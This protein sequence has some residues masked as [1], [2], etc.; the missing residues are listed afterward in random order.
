[1]RLDLKLTLSDKTGMSSKYENL[2]AICHLQR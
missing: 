1:L 2:V